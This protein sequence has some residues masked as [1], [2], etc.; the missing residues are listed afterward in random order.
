VSDAEPPRGTLG[1]VRNAGVLLDLLSEGPAY[2]QLSD[3]AERS[4]LSLPTVH[5]LLRS[6]VAA[7]L[8]EQDPR[9]S[10][11]G[12]GPELVRLSERYLERLP[13]LQTIHPYLIDLR[14]RTAAT[15]LLARRVRNTVVYLERIEGGHT[16][17]LQRAR[18]TFPVTAT[19]AGRVLIGR[20]GSEAWKQLDCG[21][22]G[23]DLAE[24]QRWAQ[25]DHVVTA[26]DAPRGHEEV[27]VPIFASDDTAMGA[28]A[29][30]GGPPEFTGEQLVEAVLPELQQTAELV[31]RMADHG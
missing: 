13:L 20:A 6:L 28:L 31:T 5:R 24:L 1:T 11:Y 15:L 3:L 2:R 18:R 30:R 7:G 19:A 23:P 27:A 12:L 25:A 16:G 26:V 9:S 21:D 22:D 10:R 17:Q 8:V 14:N 29:A 4:R